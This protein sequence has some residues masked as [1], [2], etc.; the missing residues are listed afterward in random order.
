MMFID[1]FAGH[2]GSVHDSKILRISP[3][4]TAVLG[5]KD[6]LPNAYH[7]IGDGGY[8]LMEW[9]IV[10]FKDNGHLTRHQ[11]KFAFI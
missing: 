3:L 6:F 9:L 4:Y 7:I 8:P 11:Q 5:N 10:P 2:V 1:C